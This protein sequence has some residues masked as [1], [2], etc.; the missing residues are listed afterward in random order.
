VGRDPFAEADA[1]E[2]HVA[3]K[4]KHGGVP[5]AHLHHWA[6]KQVL[7]GQR[8]ARSARAGEQAAG[9]RGGGEGQVAHARVWRRLQLTAART[10]CSHVVPVD[11]LR[12]PCS[13]Q[14]APE[15]PQPAQP[16]QQPAAGTVAVP[17]A[18]G[19][20]FGGSGGFGASAPLGTTTPAAALSLFGAA[21][22]TT[23]AMTASAGAAAA[24]SAPLGGGFL[25]APFSGATALAPQTSFGATPFGAAALPQQPN[26][27]AKKKSTSS[28]R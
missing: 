10:R 9:G 23:T 22:A 11:S 4:H 20:L 12:A 7:R 8:H 21:P 13:R 2:A 3:N 1:S 25:G 19:G 17:A 16:A 24:P 28:R 15:Q 26:L 27:R 18:G 14:K 5:R 6:A